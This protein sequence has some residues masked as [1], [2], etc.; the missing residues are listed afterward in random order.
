MADRVLKS[1]FPASYTTTAPFRVRR[2][3]SAILGPSRAGGGEWR[4]RGPFA[5]L[6]HSQLAPS[7]FSAV[8]TLNR[9][10]RSIS[11]TELDKCKPARLIGYPIHRQDDLDDLTDGGKQRLKFIL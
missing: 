9:A 8:D 10:Q 6:A 4:T 11:I 3:A 1:A 5:S 7:E 2:F